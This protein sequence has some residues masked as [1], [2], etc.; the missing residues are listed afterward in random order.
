VRNN[1]Y[2]THKINLSHSVLTACFHYISIIL[3]GEVMQ[4]I[5]AGLEKLFFFKIGIAI[6]LQKFVRTCFEQLRCKNL[7][8]T[9]AYLLTA[10]TQND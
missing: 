8:L 2:A 3:V 5:T 10:V 7:L 4:L 1:W 9:V 6:L